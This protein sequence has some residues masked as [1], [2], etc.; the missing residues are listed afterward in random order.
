MFI[1]GLLHAVQ[2]NEGIVL[3]IGEVGSGKTLMS[4]ILL[5]RLPDHIETV[6]LPNPSFSRNEII[7]VIARDLGITASSP[8]MR[9]EA[10]QLELIKRHDMG[11]QVMVFI[12]EAHTMPAESIEEVRRLSNLETDNHKLVQLVLCGQPELDTLLAAP[13]LRQVRDRIVYR[14]ML[15]KLSQN[16]AAAYL[17][18]RLHVAGWRGSRL[19]SVPGEQLLLNDA[20]GRARRINLIADKAL[21]AAFA[22]NKKQVDARHVRRAISDAGRNFSSSFIHKSDYQTAAAFFFLLSSLTLLWLSFKAG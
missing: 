21:L 18:H 11:R 16:D 1:V 13:Q 5:S 14:L 3:I 22:E 15:N 9:L 4:R 12:D 17:N 10:L 6:Y 2:Q 7:D 20:N 8:G 19:F